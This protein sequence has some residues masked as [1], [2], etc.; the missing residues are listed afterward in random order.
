ML[1]GR[2]T[3][4]RPFLPKES[5]ECL[6]LSLKQKKS[7]YHR[8]QK[9]SGEHQ[10]REINKHLVNGHKQATNK[11]E[12]E[13]YS[14]FSAIIEQG[15]ETHLEQQW[16]GKNHPQVSKWS[17][18][19][20]QS[21]KMWWSAVAGD[22]MW[23]PMKPLLLLCPY[24]KQEIYTQ[25]NSVSASSSIHHL[26]FLQYIYKVVLDWDGYTAWPSLDVQSHSEVQASEWVHC[27]RV[28]RKGNENL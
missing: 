1:R 14:E 23:S 12:W 10:G 6:C 21:L 27:L 28:I 7:C 9:H 4:Q 13:N 17:A 18:I 3:Q 5:E 26:T 16:R 2:I 19:N 24:I 25:S 22:W 20:L 11:L 15:S 8:F